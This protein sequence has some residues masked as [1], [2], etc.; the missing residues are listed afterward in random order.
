MPTTRIDARAFRQEGDLLSVAVQ[1]NDQVDP[2]FKAFDMTVPTGLTLAEMGQVALDQP[3]EPV[4]DPVF[5]GT[6]D[7][8]W[9]EETIVGP[10]G[11]TYT[12]RVLDSITR[13]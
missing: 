4:P 9:H 3:V 10:Q 11:E 7:L 6:F 8:I 5:D 12:R 13:I 1:D 2:K